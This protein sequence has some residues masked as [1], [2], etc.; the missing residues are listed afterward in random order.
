MKS[1]KISI[2]MSNYNNNKYIKEAIESVINQ[3]S[4]NWKLIICDDCSTDN[5]LE[6]IRLYLKNKK[7]KLLKNSKNLGYIKSLKKLLKNSKTEILGILD[8]DDVLTKNAVKIILDE[9]E[10][11]LKWGFIYSQYICY[12]ENLNFIC[13]GFCQKIPKGKTS[14]HNYS[15]THFKTFKKKD[16]MKTEG[17]DD[18]IL[19][20]EDKDLTYKMEEVTKLH[21]V[22]KILYKYR[23]LPDSQSHSP[24]KLEIGQS[25]NALAKYN[26][27]QRRLHTNIPNL[28]KREIFCVTF[29]AGIRNIKQKRFKEVVS[30]LLKTIKILT[31]N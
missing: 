27:Y 8:G 7:I 21:F 14:M 30:F 24:T 10:K 18:S 1:Q 15:V 2:L 19:Y 29:N 13:K 22:D 26:A 31:Q 3:S 20:A 25:S 9:Y 17:L 6:V 28:T 4:P 11:N 23:I 16:Y 5:S 12:D